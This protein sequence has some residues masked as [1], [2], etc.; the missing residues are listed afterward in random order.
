LQLRAAIQSVQQVP[1]VFLA[2]MF[3]SRYVILAA[4]GR[5]LPGQLSAVAHELLHGLFQGLS[6]V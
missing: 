6:L 1:E 3:E 5:R 2:E 4:A